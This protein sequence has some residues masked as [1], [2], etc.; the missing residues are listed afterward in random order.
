MSCGL[1]SPRALNPAFL[2]AVTG[3]SMHQYQADVSLETTAV[4]RLEISQ[5]RMKYLRAL[6]WVNMTADELMVCQYSSSGQSMHILM[7]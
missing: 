2:F 1:P 7:S 3:N 6:E 4:P 5:W